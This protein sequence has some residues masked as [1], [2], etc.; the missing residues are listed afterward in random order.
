[1]LV[2]L[3]QLQDAARIISLVQATESWVKNETEFD[4]VSHTALA[5]MSVTALPTTQVDAAYVE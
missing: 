3:R 5:S 2:K 4:K 1:M